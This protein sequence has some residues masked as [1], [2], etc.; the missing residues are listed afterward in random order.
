MRDQKR[1]AAFEQLYSEH[2]SALLGFLVY[3]TGDRTLAE[4]VMADTFERVLRAKKGYDPSKASAKTWLYTIALNCLRDHA[5][6]KGAETRAMERVGVLTGPDPSNAADHLAE[7]DRIQRA[8]QQLSEDEREAVAL[9][10]GG[11]LSLAEIAKVI[12]EPQTT[13]EGRV[14]RALKRLRDDL[15]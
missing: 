8:M 1:I 14:Y 7:K 4:D 5:R 12:G 15:G 6:R 10:Y 13:V 11:D 3:R 2:A 9:R